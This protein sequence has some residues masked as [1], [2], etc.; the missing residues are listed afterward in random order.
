MPRE[1]F[2]RKRV[3]RAASIVDLYL[4]NEAAMAAYRRRVDAGEED[5]TLHDR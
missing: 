5:G 1:R 2:V 4:P 3:D